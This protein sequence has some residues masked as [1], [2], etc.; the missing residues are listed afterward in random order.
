MQ[1]V[2]LVTLTEFGRTAKE[3]FPRYAAKRVGF[4]SSR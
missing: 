4:L 2:V 3:V 1:D